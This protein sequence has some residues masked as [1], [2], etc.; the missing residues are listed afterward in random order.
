MHVNYWLKAVRKSRL[1]KIRNQRIREM[2][3]V[4]NNILEVI[5]GRKLRWFGHIKRMGEDR[6]PKMILKW[7][8]EGRSRMENPQKN[9]EYFTSKR[10]EHATF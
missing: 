3:K 10:N 1:D 7:N 4:D 6:I 9:V 2:M 8:A 5:E